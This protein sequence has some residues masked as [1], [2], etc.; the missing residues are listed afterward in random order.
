MLSQAC[1]TLRLVAVEEPIS[2]AQSAN[3]LWLKAPTLK[4]DL[5]DAANFRRI[6]VRNHERRNIL[7]DLRAA[8]Q[9]RM[10]CRYGSTDAPR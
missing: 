10:L 3:F 9:Y 6:S 1:L 2:L 4:S 7:D 5:V 8:A